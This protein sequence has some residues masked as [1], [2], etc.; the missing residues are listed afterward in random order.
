MQINEASHLTRSP[1][2]RYT[3]PKSLFIMVA[4]LCDS[5]AHSRDECNEELSRDLCC[6]PWSVSI[7]GGRQGGI[8][9]TLQKQQLL[10]RCRMPVSRQ[11]VCQD[12]PDQASAYVLKR[13]VSTSSLSVLLFGMFLCPS[14]RKDPTTR[15]PEQVHARFRFVC[16][17]LNEKLG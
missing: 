11:S 6:Q 5:E 7:F 1:M 14:L 16:F 12:S 9:V 17:D 3:F 10:L 4:S 8:D 13:D 15:E 2:S